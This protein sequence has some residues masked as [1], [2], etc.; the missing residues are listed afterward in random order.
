MPIHITTN[1][2]GTKTMVAKLTGY[3]KLTTT[4]TSALFIDLK[5]EI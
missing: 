5:R 4:V 3:E 1:T 2:T